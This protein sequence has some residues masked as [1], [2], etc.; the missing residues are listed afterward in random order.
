ML[1]FDDR[2][3]A[4]LRIPPNSK[5]IGEPLILTPYIKSNQISKARELSSVNSLLGDKSIVSNSGYFTVD[6]T[7]NSNLFFW[8]FRKSS[9]DW[10]N[11]PFLLWLQ[12]GPG[13]SSMYGLFEENG[14]YTMTENG[15]KKRNHSWTNYYN[16]LYIDQPVGTGFSFTNSSDG[17]IG[18]QEKVADHLYEALT[19]FFKFYPELKPNAFYIT[20][21]SYAGKFI[22]SISHKI[23]NLKKANLTDINLKGLFM[24]SAYTNGLAN[25]L[26]NFCFQ[27][28]IIDSQTKTRLQVQE[29][30][31]ESYIKS[32]IWY[33]ASILA[34]ELIYK[35]VNISR[36][37]MYDYRKLDAVT[38]EKYAQFLNEIRIRK[39]LHVG[40]KDFFPSSNSVFN[41]FTEDISKSV[42]PLVEEL[43][44]H[45]PVAFVGGQ[46]DIV[47]AYPLALNVMKKLNWSGASDYKTAKRNILGKNVDGYYKSAGNLKDIFI[48]NAGHMVTRDQPRAILDLLEKFVN[49]KL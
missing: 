18:T 8:F 27:T 32:E 11:A 3:R 6:E 36:V 7:H 29:R 16:V 25:G 10:K 4:P 48:R 33:N 40:N 9:S 34:K 38:T 26:A 28:G 37:D 42:V 46:F 30:K 43:V 22:P 35:I 39:K 13:I 19:Q 31:I 47:V 2:F 12:G 44:E 41:N 15:L 23:H 45:Y 5:D 1:S 20:G 14:P 17:F 24:T 21:E 49:D